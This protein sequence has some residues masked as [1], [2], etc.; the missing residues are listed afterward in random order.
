MLAD[1][2]SSRSQP[3]CQWTD[4]PDRLSLQKENGLCRKDTFQIR[5]LNGYSAK[6]HAEIFEIARRG[7]G[8]DCSRAVRFGDSQLKK[9]ISVYAKAFR[10]RARCRNHPNCRLLAGTESKPAPG[11]RA[12]RRDDCAGALRA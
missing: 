11:T 10:F 7:D 8:Q 6:A 12:Q 4:E 9:E 3:S 2:I 1:G 5:P